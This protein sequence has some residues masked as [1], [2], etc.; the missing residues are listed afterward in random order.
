ML[1][2][3]NPVTTVDSEASVAVGTKRTDGANEYVYVYSPSAGGQ[4]RAVVLASGVT[5][6]TVSPTT[7]APVASGDAS[8]VVGFAQVAV[9][10]SSYFF[11]LT[12]GY[13]TVEQ[14]AVSGSLSPAKL[15]VATTSGT[16]ATYSP[17]SDSAPYLVGFSMAPLGNY[18]LTIP[19]YISIV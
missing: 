10:A 8:R 9:P 12:K 18:S 2:F 11:A 7:I 5:D 16:V 4:Y 3:T 19:A 6:Y 17:T 1:Y 13:G 15:V 14:T